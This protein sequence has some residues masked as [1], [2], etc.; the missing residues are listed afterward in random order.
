MSGLLF[1]VMGLTLDIIN[2]GFVPIY[3]PPCATAFPTAATFEDASTL[4]ALLNL[5]VVSRMTDAL[6]ALL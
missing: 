3:N 2:K 5:S 1:V 4:E 6:S